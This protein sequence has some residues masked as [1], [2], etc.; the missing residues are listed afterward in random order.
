MGCTTL[1]ADMVGP[2][3]ANEMMFTGKK[4][5]GKELAEK[6]TNINY[7]LPKTEIMPKAQDIALQ[8]AEKNIKSIYLL[9]YALS[10][11]ARRNCSSTRAFRK[12]SCTA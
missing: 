4:F 9:K 3:I 5:R 12:T 10:A 2:M 8:I 7:I 11:R 6:A 1:L